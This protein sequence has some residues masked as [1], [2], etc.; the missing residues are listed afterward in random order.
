M[1]TTE[2]LD[3]FTT[4]EITDIAAF[5]EEQGKTLWEVLHDAVMNALY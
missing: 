2:A 4:D 5:A 1:S 3:A